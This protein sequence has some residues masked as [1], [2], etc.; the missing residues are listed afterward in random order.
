[1]NGQGM[2]AGVIGAGAWGTALAQL[3]AQQAAFCGDLGLP[4]R[5]AA[6]GVP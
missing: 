2:K 5:A 1:M 3:L 6:P 4:A